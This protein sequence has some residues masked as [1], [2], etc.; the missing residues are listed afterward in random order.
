MLT[1]FKI[2]INPTP[3]IAIIF[4][5]VVPFLIFNT[6]TIINLV[7]ILIFNKEV[8]VCVCRLCKQ[9]VEVD[10]NQAAQYKE[11]RLN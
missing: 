6:I 4:N 10:E 11:T 8:E 7:V 3:V 2:I 5:L 9:E 1:F